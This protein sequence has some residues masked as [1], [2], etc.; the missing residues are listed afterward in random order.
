MFALNS[1]DEGHFY[2]IKVDY[3]GR[4]AEPTEKEPEPFKS[5]RG[6]GKIK[7]FVYKYKA[8]S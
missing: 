5:Y 3:T 2:Q 8:V 4:L 6:F 1:G 7:D